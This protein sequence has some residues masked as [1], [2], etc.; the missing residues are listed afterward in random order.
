MNTDD[1][2]SFAQA[3]W[4][5]FCNEHHVRRFGMT[6]AEFHMVCQWM[7]KDIPLPVVLRG[8]TETSGNPKTLLAC[9]EPVRRAHEYWHR[10]MG[11]T[12]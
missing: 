1:R 7:D 2:V 5:T 6:P 3:V 10:A 9:E 4:E 8:V 11:G 12:S